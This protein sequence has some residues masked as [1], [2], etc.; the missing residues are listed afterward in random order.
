MRLAHSATPDEVEQAMQLID[1]GKLDLVIERSAPS[2][3]QP[4]APERYTDVQPFSH[5]AWKARHG[6]KD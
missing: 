3:Q 5:S 6:I 4:A 1:A 2:I